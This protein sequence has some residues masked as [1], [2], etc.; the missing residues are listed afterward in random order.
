MSTRPLISIIS[1]CRNRNEHLEKSLV[2]WLYVADEIVIT[3]Y[4]SA[5]SVLESVKRVIGAIIDNSN[6]ASSATTNTTIMDT[7]R[8]KCKHICVIEVTNTTRWV[9]SPA[10]NLAAE[11]SRGKIILKLDADDIIRAD[12]MQAHP[13]SP[14][15]FYTGD[16]KRARKTEETYL[17]GVVMCAR[18]DFMAVNG[19]NEYIT[20]YGWDD[21]DLYVRLANICKQHPINN[22]YI[23]HQPHAMRSDTTNTYVEIQHNRILCTNLAREEYDMPKSTF[24]IANDAIID[25]SDSATSAT[26]ATTPTINHIVGAITINAIL[27]EYMRIKVLVELHSMLSFTRVGLHNTLYISLQNGLGN[28]LRA[29]ASGYNMY[30]WLRYRSTNKLMWKL[31]II[32]P[33]DEHCEAAHDDLFTLESLCQNDPNVSFVESV[34][35]NNSQQ[36]NYYGAT[37]RK[38]RRISAD[39][40]IRAIKPA[41]VA[42]ATTVATTTITPSNQLVDIDSIIGSFN[43]SN[44]YIESATTIIFPE[45][46]WETDAAYI[47]SLVP[48]TEIINIIDQQY[49]IMSACG[50]NVKNL[51]GLHIRAGTDTTPDDISSWPIDKKAEW[52]KWREASQYCNFKKIILRE[53]EADPSAAFYLASDS[54]K[55]Y[56][57]AIADFPGKIFAYTRDLYDRS[58]L[59]VITGLIDVLILSKTKTFYGSNW[60]SF[61]ELVV[62]FGTCNGKYAGKDF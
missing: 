16:W 25:T 52:I 3:D 49:K 13:M 37:A 42:T 17:N 8:V 57:D 5:D 7:N 48:T 50:H 35:F 10:F 18:K 6:T 58:R 4:G 21:S 31:V 34:E 32:W 28:K 14:G 9:L 38:I 11:Y 12:F 29:L 51:I 53:L 2:S 60:S 15:M 20:T 33:L 39:D 43:P 47:R 59:Q 1:A 41:T 26:S 24:T 36:L 56:T 44:I 23:E 46:S 45:Q 19:Y 54:E 61:S 27:P 22:D 55:V 30:N 40:A 62:R